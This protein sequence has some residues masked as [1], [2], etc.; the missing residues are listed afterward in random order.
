MGGGV[1]H[2]NLYIVLRWLA[3]SI[4]ICYSTSVQAQD[5]DTYNK[6]DVRDAYEQNTLFFQYGGFEK[7]GVTHSSGLFNQHLRRE[8]KKSKEAWDLYKMYRRRVFWGTLTLSTSVPLGIGLAVVTANP[9]AVLLGFG[10]PYALG[11]GIVTS[12]SNYY[13]RAIWVYNRD[14]L[15]DGLDKN[16]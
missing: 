16:Q 5:I 14:M 2:Q 9:G 13:H 4:F 8:I 11:F 12:G 7:G 10:V 1:K 6:Q 3:L 15:L